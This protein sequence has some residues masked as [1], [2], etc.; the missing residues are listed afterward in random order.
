MLMYMSGHLKRGT[1][2]TLTR[3]F[4]AWTNVYEAGRYIALD[5]HGTWS[6]IHHTLMEI[7][8][9]RLHKPGLQGYSN[10]G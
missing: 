5:T 8:F 2:F 1:N 6:C 3:A 9:A 10:S 7:G 4:D